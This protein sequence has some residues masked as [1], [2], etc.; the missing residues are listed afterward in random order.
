MFV[1]SDHCQSING[2]SSAVVA[3][4][5]GSRS[6]QL[7]IVRFVPSMYR[8]TRC[9]AELSYSLRR[10]HHKSTASSVIILNLLL[11]QQLLSRAR[12]GQPHDT[13]KALT[14]RTPDQH[15]TIQ[16]PDG[17]SCHLPL[18][19]LAL[20]R[21]LA[22]ASVPPSPLLVHGTGTGASRA[23]PRMGWKWS[24]VGCMGSRA[25][26]SGAWYVGVTRRRWGVGY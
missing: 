26:G 5:G 4:P 14:L 24:G 13:P 19:A 21:T 6:C 10:I 18:R 20:H 12:A 9:T 25:A 15:R 1:D 22:A 3:D 16:A 23:R 2:A 11:N 7:T 8:C 17:A